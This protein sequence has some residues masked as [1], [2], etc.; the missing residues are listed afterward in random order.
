MIGLVVVNGYC[1]KLMAVTTVHVSNDVWLIRA[2][3]CP[4]TYVEALA[5]IYHVISN[6][7][8]FALALHC[9][10]RVYLITIC[11]GSS[12]N[13][14]VYT[15]R[16]QLWRAVHSPWSEEWP[17]LKAATILSTTM[18]DGSTKG[19]C[20]SWL[21]DVGRA[22]REACPDDPRASVPG[23]TKSAFDGGRTSIAVD[24]RAREALVAPNPQ[25]RC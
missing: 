1:C 9:R 3:S 11:Y 13:L 19:P 7:R 23:P 18:D 2:D 25:K 6:H 24:R 10:S 5:K 20:S 17:L 12:F 4:R 15:A 16:H 21:M 22:R 8:S 14:N